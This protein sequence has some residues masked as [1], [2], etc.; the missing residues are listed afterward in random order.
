MLLR[1]IS[2][3]STRTYELKFVIACLI[4]CNDN[5]ISITLLCFSCMLDVVEVISILDDATDGVSVA[6]LL[7]P[8][9]L[10]I[11]SQCNICS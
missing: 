9:R 7:G 10:V 11:T 4:Y 6:V 2:S 5:P 3:A 8:V 1:T